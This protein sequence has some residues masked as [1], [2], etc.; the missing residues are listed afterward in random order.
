M[1]RTLVD[2]DDLVAKR[3]I[4][5]CHFSM[6]KQTMYGSKE[7]DARKLSNVNCVCTS[8]V[9][10]SCSKRSG[11]RPDVAAGGL[12]DGIGCGGS[13]SSAYLP[14]PRKE[15]PSSCCNRS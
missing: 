9:R 1:L 13:G 15:R 3:G 8:R 4:R 10:S 2:P 7:V 14:Y 5:G 12:V 11:P 6:M